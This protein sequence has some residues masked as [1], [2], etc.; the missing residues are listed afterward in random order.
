[1]WAVL[2]IRPRQINSRLEEAQLSGATLMPRRPFARRSSAHRQFSRLPDSVAPERHSRNLAVYPDPRQRQ[3]QFDPGLAVA[4]TQS[5]PCHGFALRSARLWVAEE[6][7]TTS[8]MIDQ[9][10]LAQ[11]WAEGWL[12]PDPAKKP[13]QARPWPACLQSQS[14]FR[15]RFSYHVF[16]QIGAISRKQQAIGMAPESP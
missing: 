5:P 12:T 3:T 10:R 4:A 2:A 8:G 16:L 6:I 13:A 15:A 1:M 14:R 11:G 9:H 7:R